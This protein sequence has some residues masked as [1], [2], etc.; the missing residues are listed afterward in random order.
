MSAGASEREGWNA[1][2]GK[3]GK[4]SVVVHTHT[5][6]TFIKCLGLQCSFFLFLDLKTCGRKKQDNF[7]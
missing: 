5:G 3:Q 7:F 6:Y 4:G 2:L 1:L